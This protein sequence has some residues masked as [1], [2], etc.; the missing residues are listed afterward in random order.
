MRDRGL[1]RLGWQVDRVT[2]QEL[3]DDFDGTIAELVELYHLRCGT[4]A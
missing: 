1:R 4:A 3:T 2:D